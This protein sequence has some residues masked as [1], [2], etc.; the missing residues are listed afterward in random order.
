[1]HAGTQDQASGWRIDAVVAGIRKGKA[2]FFA[3][4]KQKA[5]VTL[6]PP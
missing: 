2:F 3:K 4:K 6:S 1:M 5:F